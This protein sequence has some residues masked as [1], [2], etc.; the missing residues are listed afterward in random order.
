LAVHRALHLWF[1]GG[2][3]REPDP[4]LLL[5]LVDQQY[6]EHGVAQFS[7]DAKATR[8]RLRRRAPALAAWVASI[9]GAQPRSELSL[10]DQELRARGTV[11]LVVI[12]DGGFAIA[13]IKTGR[14]DPNAVRA[15]IT[16]YAA[17]VK[18]ELRTILFTATAFLVNGGGLRDLPM[19]DDE[20]DRLWQALAR[21]RAAAVIESPQER[22]GPTNCRGC[23]ARSRCEGHWRAV[24]A[25]VITDALRGHVRRTQCSE[26]GH[27]AVEVLVDGKA[28]KITGLSASGALRPGADVAVLELQ[29]RAEG[30]DPGHRRATSDTRITA[31]LL[32]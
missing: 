23:P 30:A 10:A 12:G 5:E 31:Y 25:G 14:P 11:D 4:T 26:N 15:Q 3:W 24:D 32:A 19:S 18:R 20:A 29:P 28:Q 13:D 8:E 6:A 27:W 22:P 17:L 21:E 1:D 9:P 2:R 16:V 7:T